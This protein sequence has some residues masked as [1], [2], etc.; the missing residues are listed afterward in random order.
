MLGIAS[1]RSAVEAQQLLDDARPAEACFIAGGTALQLGW[2][3]R[4]PTLQLIDISALPEAQG[5]SLPV[6]GWLRVGAATR[7]ET[8]RQH[9]LVRRHAPLLASACDSL[10]ALAVRHLA[11]LGGNVGWRCGDTLAALL[12]LDAQ[13]E[14][15]DG[16]RC[17]LDGLLQEPVLPLIVA[18]WL[19][20]SEPPLLALYEKL[21]L[22]AAFS[23][24]RLALAFSAGLQQG[25]LCALRIGVSGAG[26]PARRMGEAERLLL[27]QPLAA[28]ETGALQAAC[29]EDLA[30]CAD[31][32]PRARLAARLLAGH[33][34]EG[35]RP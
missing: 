25:R 16:R 3:E 23:P 21:G 14:L 34:G 4:T 32:A 12:A 24:A 28:L 30:G 10:A 22:R 31:A 26:L 7:L 35:L 17:P 8:L 33:L 29:A 11:T 1:P 5:I 18:L 20:C 2:Q 15:A 27:A 19:D 6:D 9:V 13:A